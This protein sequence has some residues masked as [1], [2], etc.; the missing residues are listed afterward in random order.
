MKVNSAG[1]MPIIFA[2]AI[3]FLPTLFSFTNLEAG[4]G[5]A[6]YLE[7][8]VTLVHGGLTQLW[9]LPLRSYTRL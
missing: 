9:L 2:Q 5:I 7:T 1:V 8:T 4:Q 6:K 3:M